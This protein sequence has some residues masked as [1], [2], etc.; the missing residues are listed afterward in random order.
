MHKLSSK[1]IKLNSGKGLNIDLFTSV[2]KWLK[3]T[4][5]VKE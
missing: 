3:A 1:V 2:T 5:R 4:F